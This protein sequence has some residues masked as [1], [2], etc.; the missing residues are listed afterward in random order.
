MA[1]EDS[2]MAALEGRLRIL[3]DREEIRELVSRYN[4]VMDN[5]ELEVMQDLFTEDVSLESHDG[6]MSAVGRDAVVTMLQDR[7]AVLGP[8][9]HWS[10]DH[11]IFPDPDDPD[12]A[13]GEVGL[14]SEMSRYG[15]AA[16]ALLRYDDVYQRCRDGKWRF[17]SRR[18]YFFYYIDPREYPEALESELRV[19]S[20]GSTRTEVAAGFPES[21]PSWTDYYR[22]FPRSGNGAGSA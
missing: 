16:M 9:V 7:W 19:R 22:R 17:A 4:A 14:H 13:T 11:R 8:S 10:H 12:R 21:L 3:E 18:L 2:R 15:A 20:S 6:V 1:Y 5:R